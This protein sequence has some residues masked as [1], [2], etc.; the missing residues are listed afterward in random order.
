MNNKL[1]KRILGTFILSVPATLICAFALL[2]FALGDLWFALCITGV[3]LFFTAFFWACGEY[4]YLED[5]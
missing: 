3:V 4:A 1:K 5:E 2:M